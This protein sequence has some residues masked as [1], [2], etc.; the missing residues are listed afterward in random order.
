VVVLGD[1][2]VQGGGIR[3]RVELDALV[4]EVA[5]DRAVGARDVGAV[6]RQAM[7]VEVGR[8]LFECG[9]ELE[10]A[11]CH[12]RLRPRDLRQH[13]AQDSRPPARDTVAHSRRQ[14]QH[15]EILLLVGGRDV[16]G[17]DR[18]RER[19]ARTFRLVRPH[20]VRGPSR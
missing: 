10:R 1:E 3:E 12:R 6:G 8:I 18:T 19:L 11:W 20:L 9:V 5:V 16:A 2:C 15:V 7:R 14:A 13:V 17:V 4:R